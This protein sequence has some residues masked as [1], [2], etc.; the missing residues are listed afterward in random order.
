VLLVHCRKKS[1]PTPYQLMGL[2]DDFQLSISV[3]A[4]GRPATSLL[5]VL[6]YLLLLASM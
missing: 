5:L 1:L 4:L 2:R 6:G 3:H